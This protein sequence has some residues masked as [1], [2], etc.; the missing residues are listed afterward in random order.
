MERNDSNKTLLIVIIAIIALCGCLTVSC[1]AIAF[2]SFSKIDKDTISE[3]ITQN[4][5]EQFTQDIESLFTPEPGAETDAKEGQTVTDEIIPEGLTESELKIIQITES[6]RGITAKEK[7]APVY[8][9]E[10][11]LRQELTEQLAEV[12]DEELA[13]ELGLY[14]MLGFAPKDFDLRQ[15]YVDLYTEQI[16]GF[17][18][19]ETNEMN[20]IKDISDYENAVTLAH[21]YTHY[22]QYNYPDFDETL[23]YDDDFCEEN[24]ETCL[25]VDALIE[26]DASLTENLIDVKD[27]ILKDQRDTSGESSA[28]SSVFESSPKFFQDTLLFPYVYGFDFVSYYYL[29]GGFDAVNDLYINLPQSI[30]QIMHPEKYLKDA[31]IEVTLEPFRSVITRSFEPVKEDVMNE[32]DIMML[33]GSGYN[34]DWQLSERQSAAGADGWGGGSYIYADDENG[35]QLFFAKIVWD[36]DK[37]AEEAETVF[38]LYCDKRFGEQTSTDAWTDTDNSS[39]YMI[40][41]EDILYW[42]ILPENF[43]S[44]NLLDMIRNGS[45]L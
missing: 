13:E 27:T 21:E 37:E 38:R 17:Y 22:L 25:I 35:N 6:T 8:K 1:C 15:F 16:A 31:P 24:G 10:E 2:Y 14:N 5:D 41:N 32:S 26:G 44:G 36:S 28:D 4:Q 11:E 30:E 20:L 42:M 39:V 3:I 33:L 34:S 19:T 18:D 43:E 23:N 40:R 29:K 7:L 12:T 45:A 9:T